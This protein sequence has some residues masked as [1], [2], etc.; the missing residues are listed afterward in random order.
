MLRAILLYLSQA[1]WARRIISSMGIARRM[2]MRFIAGETLEEALRTVEKLN[3]KGIFTTLDHLGEHVSSAEEA[4]NA[5][6]AYVAIIEKL[7]E[8]GALSNCSLKL[9]QLGLQLDYTLCLSNMRC[10]A[11]RASEYGTLVRIDME[12]ST[13]I[14]DTL[15]IFRTLQEEGLTNI[16]LVI[17]S[18]LFRSAADVSELLDLGTRIRLCKGAYK[19]PDSIAFT[20]KEEIDS[21]FDVL[22][23]MLIEGAL[24]HGSE[25]ASPDGKIPPIPAIATHDK[26]RIDFALTTAGAKGLSNS[27]IEFQ[28]LNGIRSDLQIELAQSGYPVRVYV[29]YG[30][31]WYPYVMRRM[32]ER[33]ANLV[34][35]LKNIFNR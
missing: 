11:T 10:I 4:L 1:I 34:L 9:S 23:S 33:P 17:Q 22:T 25:P 21:N 5:T 29:P 16:G 28:M 7:H 13:T 35:I 15:R 31:E 24:A 14:D 19:E 18:Y 20:K 2:A 6:D 27:A 26:A 32:A 30:T 3:Q 12:E 8:A